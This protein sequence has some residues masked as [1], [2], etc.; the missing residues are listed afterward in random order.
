M[1][2]IWKKTIGLNA[3]NFEFGIWYLTYWPSEKMDSYVPMVDTQKI[4]RNNKLDH[5]LTEI[6]HLS[7]KMKKNMYYYIL[8]FELC[9]H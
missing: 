9:H 6:A 4:Q 3:I 2:H 8:T 1:Q 5:Q 7:C